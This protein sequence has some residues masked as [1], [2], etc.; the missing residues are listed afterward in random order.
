MD[1]C[2]LDDMGDEE[3][4][5]TDLEEGMDEDV[6]DDGS[7]QKLI[8]VAPWE[9]MTM[10]QQEPTFPD[11]T[12]T[13]EGNGGLKAEWHKWLHEHD[14][15]SSSY[16]L[17][18]LFWPEAWWDQIVI[19][20]NLYAKQHLAHAWH[21]TCSTEV[22]K[23]FG[24]LLFMSQVRLPCV[25]TGYWD[26]KLYA[27]QAVKTSG[28]TR[29][30]FYQM[31][32][33]LHL[34]DYTE[35]SAA[36]KTDKAFKLQ[37]EF[38]RFTSRVNKV[39]VSGVHVNIDEGMVKGEQRRHP[40]KK[41]SPK[42]PIR[43]GTEI[44]MAVDQYGVCVFAKVSA[45]NTGEKPK[46]SQDKTKQ[47]GT[48]TTLM[49]DIIDAIHLPQRVFYLD[50]GYG[51]FKLMYLTMM[52]M[53]KAVMI[54]RAP[55]AKK[56]G[57][58]WLL[59]IF[60]HM[61]EHIPATA[62][63]GTSLTMYHK[64]GFAATIWKDHKLVYVLSSVHNETVQPHTTHRRGD[65]IKAKI[66]NCVEEYNRY[67]SCCD[68]LNASREK[69]DLQLRFNRWWLR[70]FFNGLF[71]TALV[72]SWNVKKFYNPATKTTFCSFVAK[73]WQVA[74]LLTIYYEGQWMPLT[75]GMQCQALPAIHP[76]HLGTNTPCF[77]SCT[78]KLTPL[79]IFPH[80]LGIRQTP[81]MME[82]STYS[83]VDLSGTWPPASCQ[84]GCGVG[85]LSCQ[86]LPLTFSTD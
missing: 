34:D 52:K 53:Q 27:Q 29:F 32:K 19:Q 73:I 30:R 2:R 20:T 28:M 31:K 44:K 26:H 3:C 74:D 36:E 41:R 60:C 40:C 45:T 68:V 23:F 39:W 65:P 86:S 50:Q 67:H 47:A 75:N 76:I 15:P 72:N 63:R 4:G 6:E 25:Y 49:G 58:A 66:P 80:R 83:K 51:S 21:P 56:H 38:Q 61:R 16:A 55:G 12:A 78:L 8:L 7:D 43:C 77:F 81:G 37:R 17:L 64:G 84:L 13:S 62:P 46:N 57:V 82:N 18:C 48:N 42:K 10:Y 22:K 69:V 33:Y 70:V 35:F 5:Y 54:C 71:G 59:N 85:P 1:R 24:V 11:T 14:S 9:D 79:E